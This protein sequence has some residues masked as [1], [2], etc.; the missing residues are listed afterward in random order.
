MPSFFAVYVQLNVYCSNILQN[1]YL[2]KKR[3][4]LTKFLMA[5]FSWDYDVSV[6]FCC[7]CILWWCA[8]GIPNVLHFGTCSKYNALVIELLG[9]T[10]ED[11]F[12]LCDRR[13]S[14][15]TVL[16][17]ATQLVSLYDEFLFTFLVTAVLCLNL[18]EFLYQAV[19]FV[20]SHYSAFCSNLCLQYF[21]AFGRVSWSWSHH[22]WH[23]S[24]CTFSVCSS[25]CSRCQ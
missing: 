1:F 24:A 9:S 14:L 19:W 2:D 15:K 7:I 23:C 22:H 11:L 10:L 8:E 18:L 3:L 16:M 4:K 21:V 17:L 12:N 20:C 13:F 25:A 6:N 5:D